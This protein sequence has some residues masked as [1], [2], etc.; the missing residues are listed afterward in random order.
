MLKNQGNLAKVTTLFLELNASFACS[1]EYTL[2]ITC[3]A[4]SAAHG[5]EQLPVVIHTSVL[6]SY[7][8]SRS[9]MI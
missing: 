6:L 8:I 1:N 2:P 7:L 5:S 9:C 4:V 3:Y